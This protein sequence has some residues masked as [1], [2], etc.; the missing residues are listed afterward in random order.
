MRIIPKFRQKIEIPKKYK[1]YFWDYPDGFAT[2]ETFILRILLYG[3]FANIQWLYGK[4]SDECYYVA[5][6]Y[7]KIHRGVKFWIKLWEKCK[8]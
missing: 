3:K 5:T 6:T 2:L 7:P 8:K 4:F 1:R